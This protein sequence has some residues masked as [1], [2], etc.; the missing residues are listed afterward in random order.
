MEDK[1]C[2]VVG[3]GLSAGGMNPLF[4]FFSSIPENPGVAF[5]V[6][7]HL[8]RD[9]QSQMKKI[10]S[11]YTHLP[12]NTILDGEAVLPNRIYL[13]PENTTVSIKDRRLFLEARKAEDIINYAIDD[14]FISLAKD[15]KEKSIGII[16]SGMGTDGTKG[17][18]A[19][20]Q[21]CGIIIV[22]HPDS[23]EYDGMTNSVVYGDH[24]DYILDPKDMGKH[25]LE[26]IHSKV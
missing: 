8:K 20:E 12:V 23:S 15:V 10:L 25:L 1:D 9:Y 24:P 22:Q 17:A 13:M 4:D 16:L 18:I 11:K 3:I 6:V 21:A 26:Y 19:I 5:I 7:Q 14:F 2:F